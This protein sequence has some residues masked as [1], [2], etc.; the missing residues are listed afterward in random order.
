MDFRAATPRLRR[1]LIT[2]PTGIIG[3]RTFTIILTPTTA[4]HTIDPV[5]IGRTTAII[6]IV[7]SSVKRAD[8]ATLV[9][10]ADFKTV[11][12]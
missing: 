3:T 8:Y 11:N 10:G 6:A 1:T 9:A 12:Y 5:V 4:P 2:I 7:T